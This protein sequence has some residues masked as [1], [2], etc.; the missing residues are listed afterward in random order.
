MKRLL[1][2]TVAVEAEKMSCCKLQQDVT[3]HTNE[4]PNNS[5]NL[6]YLG[7]EIYLS[8]ECQKIF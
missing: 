1:A 7:N 3:L 8:Q 2:F 5:C 4:Y 6:S